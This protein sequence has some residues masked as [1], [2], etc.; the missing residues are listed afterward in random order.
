VA[1]LGEMAESQAAASRFDDAGRSLLRA[2]N[3][4]AD[5]LAAMS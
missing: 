4:M 1:D 5:A 3:Q 2:V